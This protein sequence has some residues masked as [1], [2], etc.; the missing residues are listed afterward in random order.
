MLAINIFRDNALI[1]FDTH[2]RNSK[3]ANTFHEVNI[4]NEANQQSEGFA[5]CQFIFNIR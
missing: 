5:L 4:N 3:A 2:V 1:K